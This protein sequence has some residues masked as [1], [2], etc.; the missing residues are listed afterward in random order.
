MPVTALAAFISIRAIFDAA[1]NAR[2]RRWRAAPKAHFAQAGET[3][4]RAMMKRHRDA[5]WPHND[6]YTNQLIFMPPRFD[7]DYARGIEQVRCA[8]IAL[9]SQK[10]GW[11]GEAKLCRQR[12]FLRHEYD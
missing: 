8:L 1:E 9:T 5:R 7:D 6:H 10:D 12:T 4:M 3:D 11:R 2:L